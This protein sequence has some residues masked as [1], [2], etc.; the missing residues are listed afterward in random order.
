LRIGT[1]YSSVYYVS[2]ANEPFTKVE[3]GTSLSEQRATN[4]YVGVG[5]DMALRVVRQSGFWD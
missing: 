3:A 1:R 5:V 2:M 4:S